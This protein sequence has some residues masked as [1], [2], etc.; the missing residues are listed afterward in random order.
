MFHFETR[1]SLAT[2]TDEIE[3]ASGYFLISDCNVPIIRPRQ[4][5]IE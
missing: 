3:S 4:E 5:R 1:F 2:M